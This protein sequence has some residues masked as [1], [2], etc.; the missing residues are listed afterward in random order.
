V[1][2]CGDQLSG[3]PLCVHDQAKSI[4]KR[5]FNQISR[6]AARLQILHGFI[7]ADGQI[8]AAAPGISLLQSF[9]IYGIAQP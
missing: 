2:L 3:G 1:L 6:G 5:H 9:L 8:S 4:F 7:E